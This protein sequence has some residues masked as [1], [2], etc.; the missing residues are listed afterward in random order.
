MSC[1]ANEYAIADDD[2]AQ[3]WRELLDERCAGHHDAVTLMHGFLIRVARRELYRGGT[4]FTTREIDDIAAQ[5]AADSLVA[6]LGKLSS[7]RGDS[8]L[9]TWAYRFVVLELSNTLKCRRR[10]AW[11]PRL[12]MELDD[13]DG[14]AERI[15]H[16]P[17]RHAEA[18][19]MMA[20][21]GHAVS[22][23]LTDQQRRVFLEAVV[24]GAP[25]RTVADKYGMSRNT[26]Y[27]SIFDSRRKIRGFLTAN[28]FD[29]D[30][31]ALPDPV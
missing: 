29:V 8:K 2:S 26:L 21:V 28:G 27:K 6:V 1:E 18:R 14:F 5:V 7:F 12:A 25:P 15:H 19:E 13:W 31:G 23:V 10:H 4:A 22:A 17:S 3:W 20:A 24:E 9:T 30:G 16:D 11:I